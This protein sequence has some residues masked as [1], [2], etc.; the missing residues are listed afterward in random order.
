MLNVTKTI[1]IPL[2]QTSFLTGFHTYFDFLNAI[3]SWV[4][5]LI[6]L[7]VLSG[8]RQFLNTFKISFQCI[9][10]KTQYYHIYDKLEN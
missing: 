4:L 6:I 5:Y 9:N 8:S 10:V 2:L 7:S 1:V 3:K